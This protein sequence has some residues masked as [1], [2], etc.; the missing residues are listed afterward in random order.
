MDGDLA[1]L[2]PANRLEVEDRASGHKDRGDTSPPGPGQ[3]ADLT[4]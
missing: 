3:Q 1:D 2:R 4:G